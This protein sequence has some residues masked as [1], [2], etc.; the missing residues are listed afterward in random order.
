MVHARMSAKILSGTSR[1]FVH[2]ESINTCPLSVCVC[3]CVYTYTCKHS[4]TLSIQT[5]TSYILCRF[6]A[7]KYVY[8]SVNIYTHMCNHVL[9][10]YLYVCRNTNRE[11]CRTKVY[12]I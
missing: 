8:I 2:T 10:L 9:V 6:C 4:H 11:T 7:R 5:N 3:V 1:A 12:T